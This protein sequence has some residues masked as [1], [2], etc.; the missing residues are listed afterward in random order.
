MIS[1]V[2]S[3]FMY[4][5]HIKS[6]IANHSEHSFVY[7]YWLHMRHTQHLHDEVL[8]VDIRFKLHVTQLKQLTQTQTHPLHCFNAYSDSQTI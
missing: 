3:V 8:S 4:E 7:C 5:G 2:F 6:E 1:I